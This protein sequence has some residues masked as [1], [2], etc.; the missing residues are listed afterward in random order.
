MIVGQLKNIDLHPKDNE[1]YNRA[2]ELELSFG[3]IYT[4]IGSEEYHILLW[5]PWLRGAPTKKIQR[6]GG[7]RLA[8]RW[9]G[10]KIIESISFV[11]PLLIPC[12]LI[13]WRSVIDM[14]G[15]VRDHFSQAASFSATEG[16][17]AK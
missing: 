2:I 9:K 15:Y 10:V 6:P 16:L 5:E 7:K 13:A 1:E 12:S 14:F 4:K 11:P 17:A 8:Q 3:E